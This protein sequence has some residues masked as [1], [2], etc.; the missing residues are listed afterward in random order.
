MGLRL[1][2]IA[3][4]TALRQPEQYDTAVLCQA[5]DAVGWT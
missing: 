2:I 1:G 4:S 5:G 3:D